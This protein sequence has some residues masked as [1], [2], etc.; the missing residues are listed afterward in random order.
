[1][2]HSSYLTQPC[3]GRPSPVRHHMWYVCCPLCLFR[4]CRFQPSV[5]SESQ[6]AVQARTVHKTLYSQTFRTL[7]LEIAKPVLQ[8]RRR[9]ISVTT[10]LR[11]CNCPPS[12]V[13][14]CITV[15]LFLWCSVYILSCVTTCLQYTE[16]FQKK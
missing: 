12:D 13:Q 2:L 9:P 10:R 3:P 14:V 11:C 15:W 1:M 6:D 7:L 16:F 4:T 8:N 5:C